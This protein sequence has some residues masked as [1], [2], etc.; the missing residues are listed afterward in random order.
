MRNEN[1][2]IIITGRDKKSALT[3]IMTCHYH[4][5]LNRHLFEL[6]YLLHHSYVFLEDS[7]VYSIQSEWRQQVDV[8][9]NVWPSVWWMTSQHIMGHS[10]PDLNTFFLQKYSLTVTHCDGLWD[11]FWFCSFALDY[12]GLVQIRRA[13]CEN[14]STAFFIFL[15]LLTHSGIVFFLKPSSK[16][17]KQKWYT[18]TSLVTCM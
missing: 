14:Q 1:E 6:C 12:I 16:H 8:Q 2:K 13:A 7:P 18:N 10:E 11:T 5:L 3:S 15:F 4:P 9:R 17:E